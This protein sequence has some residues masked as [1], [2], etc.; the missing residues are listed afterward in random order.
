MGVVASCFLNL[1][2]LPLLP[3]NKW[4]V[5]SLYAGD[6]LTD[7]FIYDMCRSFIVTFV[8]YFVFIPGVVLATEKSTLALGQKEKENKNNSS[9]NNSNN[10][11][12]KEKEKEEQVGEEW[13]EKGTNTGTDTGETS[14]NGNGS[15]SPPPSPPPNSAALLYGT[16]LSIID[17]S[18][19]VSSWISADIVSHLGITFIDWSRLWEL[20][21][22]GSG[23]Q[24]LVLLFVPLLLVDANSQLQLQLGWDKDKDTD[25]DKDKA[26]TEE[27]EK[28]SGLCCC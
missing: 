14:G 4:S 18:D 12:S 3:N 6:D 7:A 2:S 28:R 19:S 5:K 11:S 13:R 24:L 22:I 15:T 20:V 21:L 25:K 10:N 17:L 23:T 9:N 1:L 8:G 16:Y 27:T 26:K